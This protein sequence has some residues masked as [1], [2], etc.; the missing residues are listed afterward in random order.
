MNRR[1]LI[2]IIYILLHNR[3]V[4]FELEC[5]TRNV[6]AFLFKIPT[7]EKSTA[8]QLFNGPEKNLSRS[9]K[10]SLHNVNWSLVTLRGMGE[11]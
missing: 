1:T 6:N 10:R 9:I 4:H 2:N 11:D 3:T 5:N 8:N 7:T